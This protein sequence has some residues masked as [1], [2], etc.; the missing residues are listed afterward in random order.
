[1]SYVGGSCSARQ[2]GYPAPVCL[3]S[4]K[5]K[6]PS[7]QPLT[8]KKIYQTPHLTRYGNLV[9]LTQ[10]FGNMGNTDNAGVG[11]NHKTA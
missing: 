9:E 6:Q 8:T 5:G 10:S 1:M 11:H 7:Q 2:L 4:V 3:I